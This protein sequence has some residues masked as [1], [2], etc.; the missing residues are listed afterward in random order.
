MNQDMELLQYVYQ[1]TKM[2]EDNLKSLLPSVKNTDLKAH[3]HKQMSGYSQFNNQAEEEIYKHNGQ[4]K[5]NSTMSK[6]AAHMGVKMNVL[7]D[8]SASHVAE[9]TIQGS[10][11]GIVDIT[12]HLNRCS[13][14]DPAA[15]RLA[16]DVLHFEQDNIE[17]LKTFL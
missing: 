7:K 17:R 8:N 3:L 11:M 15:K 13:G 14:A 16:N 4:P 2:G 5:E 1:N 6:F 10:T 12:E 9:M